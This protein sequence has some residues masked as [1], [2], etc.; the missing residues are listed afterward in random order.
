MDTAFNKDDKFQDDYIDLQRGKEGKFIIV[1]DKKVN[2]LPF[3]FLLLGNRLPFLLCSFHW[4]EMAGNI[5][6]PRVLSKKTV[7]HVDPHHSYEQ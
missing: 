2:G 5:P 6:R 7:M 1:L 4:S 3:A